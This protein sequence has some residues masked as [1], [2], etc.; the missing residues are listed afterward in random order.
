MSRLYACIISDDMKQHRE[1]LLT[2]AKRFT[3]W[4]EMIEDGVLLD[5]RGL[6]RLIGTTKNIEKKIAAELKQRKIPVRM[7]VA[8]TIETAMLLARQGR[9]NTEFQRLPLADLDI[10]QD[11]LNVFTDLG[12]RDI[13]DLLA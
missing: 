3:H 13:N 9:E 12:L 6:G 2:I 7:A 11:T 5:V 8:E 1:T 10:E 4:I